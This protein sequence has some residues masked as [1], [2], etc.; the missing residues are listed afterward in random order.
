MGIEKI[1]NGQLRD[2]HISIFD[3]IHQTRHKSSFVVK[4]ST[5]DVMAIN[6]KD[7]YINEK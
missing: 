3:G 5:N 6:C 2:I 4:R 1:I 7:I